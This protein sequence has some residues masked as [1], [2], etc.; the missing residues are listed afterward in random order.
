MSNSFAKTHNQPDLG[1]TTIQLNQPPTYIVSVYTAM[2]SQWS[3]KVQTIGCKP[4]ARCLCGKAF[5]VQKVVIK[6]KKSHGCL[7]LVSSLNESENML[8]N[9]EKKSWK[10]IVKQAM[11]IPECL[12]KMSRSNN[13]LE[14]LNWIR[15]HCAP[16]RNLPG[17]WSPGLIG[18]SFP[19]ETTLLAF[20]LVWAR[21]Q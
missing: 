11:V 13:N 21:S 18:L 8:H 15:A 4:V 16:P 7:I 3:T 2:G 6:D 1:Y 19:K 17:S 5:E 12:N 9:Q 14:P 10:T 20:N